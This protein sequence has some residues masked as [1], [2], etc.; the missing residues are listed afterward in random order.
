MHLLN[1]NGQ[2]LLCS[3]NNGLPEV[4]CSMFGF[5]VKFIMALLGC[6]LLA[7]IGAQLSWSQQISIPRAFYI[8]INNNVAYG[9]LAQQQ[10][11]QLRLPQKGTRRILVF[12]TDSTA[13]FAGELTTQLRIKL[14]DPRLSATWKWSTNW[15]RLFNSADGSCLLFKRPGT[16]LLP[17]HKRSSLDYCEG[18]VSCTADSGHRLRLICRPLSDDATLIRTQANIFTEYNLEPGR[19]QWLEWKTGGCTQLTFRSSLSPEIGALVVEPENGFSIWQL[20]APQCLSNSLR[21]QAGLLSPSL[22]IAVCDQSQNQQLL[23]NLRTLFPHTPLLLCG[24]TAP[25]KLTRLLPQCNAAAL[26]LPYTQHISDRAAFAVR[27]LIGISG[28]TP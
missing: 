17:S 1:K 19:W 14:H 13:A 23:C 9:G 12:H 2:V 15:Q 6:C 20:P 18:W 26:R 11:M 27:Q 5:R 7:F 22:V 28:Y 4:A 21:S 24:T 8:S 3:V 25:D 10:F 16:L